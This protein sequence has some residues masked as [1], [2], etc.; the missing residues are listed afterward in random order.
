MEEKIK[1]KSLLQYFGIEVAEKKISKDVQGL[2]AQAVIG[3]GKW[4]YSTV[5]VSPHKKMIWSAAFHPHENFFATA[6]F[7]HTA[8][9]FDFKGNQ[10][11]RFE[12]EGIVNTV[13]FHP[14]KKIVATASSDHTAVLWD[15]DG[16]KM[17]TISWECGVWRVAF[18]P[19]KDILAI[20]SEK[21][22]ALCDFEGKKLKTIV[23]GRS[24][25]QVAFH[26]SKNR[27]AT[28][29]GTHDIGF[30][31]DP[32][33][34]WDLDGKQLATLGRY[35]NTLTVAADCDQEDIVA[36]AKDLKVALW[37]RKD[38][39]PKKLQGRYGQSVT[40][41]ST[42]KVMLSK[43]CKEATLWERQQPTLKQLL[44]RQVL[45]NYVKECVARKEKPKIVA[46]EDGLLPWMATKFNLDQTEL[47]T[48]WNSYPPMLQLGI[49]KTVSKYAAN[50]K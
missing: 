23:D 1:S 22:V 13:T 33:I 8:A 18:H 3:K 10:L 9:L 30:K 31:A 4:W 5:T 24:V 49:L 43:D 32:A 28:C 26:L 15:F 25:L 20:A 14:L 7:D 2:I 35:D 40:V 48:V 19:R 12:H 16:K 47:Q 17:K 27:L 39:L 45:K 50:K 11:A 41:H 29:T 42:G 37:E 36:A 6:S 46:T 44:L 34:V 38:H 21:G